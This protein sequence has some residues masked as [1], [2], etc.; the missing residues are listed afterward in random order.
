VIVGEIWIFESGEKCVGGD[1]GGYGV[2]SCGERCYCEW[3]VGDFK[4]KW[5]GNYMN[6]FGVYLR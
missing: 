4:K 5:S 6:V 2:A 1:D 3:F